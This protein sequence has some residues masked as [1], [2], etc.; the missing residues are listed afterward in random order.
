[1][2]RS[3]WIVSGGFNDVYERGIRDP[4]SEPVARVRMARLATARVGLA[5]ASREPAPRGEIA[6]R[7]AVCRSVHS[8][9]CA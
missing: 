1:M 7:A 9:A 2:I 3:G 6:V 5:V 4:F 8:T